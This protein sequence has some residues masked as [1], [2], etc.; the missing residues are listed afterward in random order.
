MGLALTIDEL[1]L[2]CQIK[3]KALIAALFSAE[4]YEAQ[5]ARAEGVTS[6]RMDPSIDAAGLCRHDF[7]G[8]SD[9]GPVGP[10]WSHQREAQR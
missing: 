8:Q 9:Q 10:A 3:D 6:A 7:S 4:S 2:P 1:P 5:G